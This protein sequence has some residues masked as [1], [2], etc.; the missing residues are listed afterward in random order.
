MVFHAP[1]AG[2]AGAE[3]DVEQV[4]R[5]P[6]GGDCWGKLPARRESIRGRGLHHFLPAVWA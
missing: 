5:E 3:G 2:E 6:D 4:E 1:D